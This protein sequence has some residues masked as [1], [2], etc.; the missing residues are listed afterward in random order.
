M[1]N[2]TT[3]AAQIEAAKGDIATLE[4]LTGAKARLAELAQEYGAAKKQADLEEAARAKQAR[5]AR[6]AGLSELRVETGELDGGLLGTTF[7]ITWMA[8]KYDMHLQSSPPAKH[9][10]F[11]FSA[12][13][14]NVF[15]FLV[16]R[17]PEQIPAQIMELAPG[18]PERAFNLYFL[19]RKRGYVLRQA[20]S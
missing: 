17:H 7:K 9:T 20:A 4:R 13:P 16:E 10:V 14:N 5:D 19:A 1:N 3:L 6:F 15:D 18:D 12:L 11:G 8:P 2:L